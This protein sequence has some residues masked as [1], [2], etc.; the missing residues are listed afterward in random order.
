MFKV[1]SQI[2]LQALVM[3]VSGMSTQEKKGIVV[4]WVG[5]PCQQNPVAWVTII[6]KTQKSDILAHASSYTKNSPG[7]LGMYFAF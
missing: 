5:L 6:M 4:T 3:T 7:I 1:R 2:L